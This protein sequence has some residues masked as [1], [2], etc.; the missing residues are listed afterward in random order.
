MEKITRVAEIK[1]YKPTFF[2]GI[3]F[4]DGNHMNADFKVKLPINQHMTAIDM[5]AAM[6]ELIKAFKKENDYY[7]SI[8]IVNLE[9]E[10][11]HKIY[12][13]FQVHLIIKDPIKEEDTIRSF[14]CYLGYNQRN[15]IKGNIE[16]ISK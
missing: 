15:V 9:G 5:L 8:L 10:F 13:G 3:W 16:F 2:D 7:K 6:Q 14:V 4:P 1:M 11:I 12:R